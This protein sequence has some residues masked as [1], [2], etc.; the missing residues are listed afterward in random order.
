MAPSSENRLL[1]M[2]VSARVRKLFNGCMSMQ[3]GT[4]V[5]L[6]FQDEA[7]ANEAAD[8]IL[9]LGN[10]H[11]PSNYPVPNSGETLDE[12]RARIGEPVSPVRNTAV[13]NDGGSRVPRK[14]PGRS[15]RRATGPTLR[16]NG[17]PTG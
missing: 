3:Q 7:A 11:R 13:A 16:R 8:Y 14:G 1:V 6:H 2:K 15:R 9:M 10:K 12:Y 5:I 4:T 17:E